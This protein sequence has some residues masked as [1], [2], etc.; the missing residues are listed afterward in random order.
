MEE[1]N[2][3]TQ[4]EL[5][6]TEKFHQL[7]TDNTYLQ[8]KA[9]KD[10]ADQ[11]AKVDKIFQDKLDILAQEEIAAESRYRD[12]KAA[13]ALAAQDYLL[14]GRKIARARNEA[15][16]EKN[17]D[18]AELKSEYAT[19][20]ESLQHKRHCIFERYRNSGGALIGA[21]EELLHPGWTRDKKGGK[22]DEEK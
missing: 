1:M 6:T 12:A 20:N 15:G 22:S 13:Y 9:R 8:N 2:K 21:E 19:Y 10:Y 11:L 16:Q 14:A 5:L 4:D 7:L 17:K 3:K 18:R